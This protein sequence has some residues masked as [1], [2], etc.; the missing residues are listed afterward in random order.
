MPPSA[1][2]ALSF[3]LYPPRSPEAE[4]SLWATVRRLEETRPDFVSV[5]YGAAG[6]NR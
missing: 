2:P 4:E 1:Y 5:T 6:S 3:E